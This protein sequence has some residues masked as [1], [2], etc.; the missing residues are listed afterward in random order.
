MRYV[1]GLKPIFIVLDLHYNVLLHK[2][3]EGMFI[4]VGFLLEL[5]W[6]V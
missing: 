4:R 5:I 1:H 6:Y 3:W 2:K